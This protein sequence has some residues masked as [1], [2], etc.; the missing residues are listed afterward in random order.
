MKYTGIESD[1]ATKKTNVDSYKN[2]L[3]LIGG[4]H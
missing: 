4:E 1:I 3:E 2:M